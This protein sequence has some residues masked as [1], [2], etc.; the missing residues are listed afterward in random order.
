MS[1]F[2]GQSVSSF[3]DA[4]IAL[5]ELE[6]A[7]RRL[8]FTENFE[9]FFWSGEILAGTEVEIAHP[10]NKI[11]SGRVILTTTGA[12]IVDGP[13]PWTNKKVYL[14]NVSSTSDANV[15]VVFLK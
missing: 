8:T 2:G 9:S 15:T 12:I 13:S 10:F 3:Q 7:L 5:R 1:N 6:S 11:P 4:N 14:A